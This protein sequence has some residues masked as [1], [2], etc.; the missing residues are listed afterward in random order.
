MR[1]PYEHLAISPGV[2]CKNHDCEN[3]HDNLVRHF[4]VGDR[5]RCF[6]TPLLLIAVLLPERESKCPVRFLTAE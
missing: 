5:A 2:F 1:G 4:H 6:F 3:D